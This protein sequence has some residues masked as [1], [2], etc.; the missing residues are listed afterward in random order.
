MG[1]IVGGFLIF[2]GIGTLSLFT[3]AIAAYLIQVRRPRRAAG[4]RASSDHV[5]ICGLGNVG[6]AASHRP[7]AATGYRVLAIE[8]AE[9]QPACRRGPRIGRRGDHRRRRARRSPRRAR[10]RYAKHM[11]I[12]AGDDA[13][14]VEI[15]AQ[16]RALVAAG[17][18]KPLLLD[19]DSEPGT[20]VRAAQL[21]CRHT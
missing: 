12:V 1:R 14:N 19:A 8:K 11:V 7:S 2:A 20:L 18:P 5:V 4:P 3:A 15:A 21:G 6:R 10:L 16:A 17:R 13:N 9:G